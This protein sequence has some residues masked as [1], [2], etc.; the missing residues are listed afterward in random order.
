MFQSEYMQIQSRVKNS[1]QNFQDLF[2]EFDETA[3]PITAMAMFPL[4]SIDKKIAFVVGLALLF[5]VPVDA[6]HLINIRSLEPSEWFSIVTQSALCV[7]L[8][9]HYGIIKGLLR[10]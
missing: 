2:R 6:Y 10:R 8:F 3:D 1:S 7:T 9:Y 4:K 5:K